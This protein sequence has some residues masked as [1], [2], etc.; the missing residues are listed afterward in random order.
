MLKS[1][2]R[3]SITL[4]A[5]WGIHLSVC[6]SYLLLVLELMIEYGNARAGMWS[7]IGMDGVYRLCKDHSE[8]QSGGKPG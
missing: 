3:A 1:M 4:G 6:H 5:C 7:I 8:F 2:G